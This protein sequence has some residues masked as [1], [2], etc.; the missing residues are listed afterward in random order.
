MSEISNAFNIENASIVKKV[1]TN[2]EKILSICP[3]NDG[4]IAVS[5]I[6]EITIYDLEKDKIVM[7][8]KKR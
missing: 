2:K 6:G 5:S 7:K 8:K 4:R 1:E 3:L